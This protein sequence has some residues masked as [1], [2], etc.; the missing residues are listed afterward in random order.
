M[1]LSDHGLI[2]C[3]RKTS[4]LEL[5]EHCEISIRSMKNYSDEVFVEQLRA[6]KFPDYS[7]CTCVKDDYPDFLTKFSSV[8][9]FVA[10]V[11]TLRVKSNTKPW[12]N[13]D[14]LSAIGNRDKHCKK[15]KQSGKEIHKDSFKCAK[16]SLKKVINNKIKL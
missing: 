16:L 6:I 5:N 4:L 11:R 8:I 14:V 12:F 15:F 7:N 3:T 13:I 10:I 9:G 1:V 2:F